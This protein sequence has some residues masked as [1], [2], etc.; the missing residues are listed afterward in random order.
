MDGKRSPQDGQR[1]KLNAQSQG[2][3]ITV[4]LT[5]TKWGGLQLLRIEAD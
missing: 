2:L 5:V 4:G 3:E 1:T